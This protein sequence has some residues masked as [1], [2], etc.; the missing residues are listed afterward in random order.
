MIN[1]FLKLVHTFF[2]FSFSLYLFE[3]LN[4]SLNTLKNEM[5]KKFLF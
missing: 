3:V 5:D 2:T 1:K 4:S